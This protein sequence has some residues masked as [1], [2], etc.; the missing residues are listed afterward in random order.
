M[1]EFN[2]IP[3]AVICMVFGYLILAVVIVVQGSSIQNLER[4]MV[5]KDEQIH[6][7]DERM[8]SVSAFSSEAMDVAQDSA[9]KVL[10][11]QGVVD[12]VL[13]QEV[14]LCKALNTVADKIGEV[15]SEAAEVKRA[16]ASVEKSCEMVKAEVDALREQKKR[17]AASMRSRDMLLWAEQDK[18]RAREFA[19]GDNVSVEEVDKELKNRPNL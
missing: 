4:R 9:K 16:S 17:E 7:L 11:F 14:A 6:D 10:L 1:I 15:I 8:N 2:W 5:D 12:S 18:E 3:T 13:R 19:F